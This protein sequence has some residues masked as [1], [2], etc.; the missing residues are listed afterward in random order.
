[1]RTHYKIENF[2]NV[3]NRMEDKS[4]RFLAQSIGVVGLNT[5]SFTEAYEGVYVIAERMS[6]YLEDSVV[7]TWDDKKYLGFPGLRSSNRYFTWK[8]P[9]GQAPA[10]PF[11]GNVDP[12]DV[13]LTMA[14]DTF[15]HTKDNEVIY[16]SCIMDDEEKPE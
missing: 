11:A 5:V 9:N 8:G 4:K 15:V 6:R 2:T 16:R 14:G 3:E 7:P 1:M 12:S 10:V 13:L